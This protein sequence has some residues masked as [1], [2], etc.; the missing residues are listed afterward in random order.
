MVNLVSPT[1]RRRL[2]LRYYLRLATVLATSI[3]VA[4]TITA[5]LML[6]TYFII[7]AEADQAEGYVTTASA[8]AS[9]RAKGAAQETLATFHESV[10]LLTEA[11]RDPAFARIMSLLT[12]ELPR[13][14]FLSDASVVFQEDGNASVSLKG[15]ARTRAELIAYTNTLK[16][17]PEFTSVNVPVGDLVADVDG[18]FTV[19]LTWVR[20]QK[21]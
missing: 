8:I 9:E 2:S 5:A 3:G 17:V 6:P 14:V 1:L 18:A 10:T 21:P 4:L 12:E 15:T 11:H 7:H 20:P 13:G 19:S 16:K